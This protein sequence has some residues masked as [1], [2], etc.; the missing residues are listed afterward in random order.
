MPC[1]ARRGPPARAAERGSRSRR[2]ARHGPD[3]LTPA[4]HNR[5]LAALPPEELAR[6]RPWLERVELPARHTL[7][8]ADA[9]ITAV[10]FP[11][12]GWIS[13]L[14]TLEDGDA[15]EVRLI[16]REGMVGLPP[17]VRDRLRALRGNDPGRQH[18]A[19]AGRGG[20]DR[21]QAH[22]VRIRGGAS[23]L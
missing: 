11:E 8:A 19:E 7:T 6:L 2:G 13:M 3:R 17:R 22:P 5:L 21:R 15:A 9:P 12:A 10:H 23:T 18:R 20:V 1:I 16:G 14:A 4:P